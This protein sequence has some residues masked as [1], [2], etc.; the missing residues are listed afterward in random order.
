ME[1]E[2]VEMQ[3][4]LRYCSRER[5]SGKTGSKQFPGTEMY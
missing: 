5:V 2:G 1:S 3:R 4:G